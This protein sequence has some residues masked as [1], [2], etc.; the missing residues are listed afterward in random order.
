MV[1]PNPV[2]RS[3]SSTGRRLGVGLGLL[4][5]DELY[6]YTPQHTAPG[7]VRVRIALFTIAIAI[8]VTSALAAY[9]ADRLTIPIMH[10]VEREAA[11]Q[12]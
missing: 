8:A 5:W 3:T 6:S 11:R 2:D 12:L 7:Y 1:A 4:V 10:Q 9:E